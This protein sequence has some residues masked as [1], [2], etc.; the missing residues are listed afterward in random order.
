MNVH[1]KRIG[2]NSTARNHDS[3]IEI[4]VRAHQVRSQSLAT[5]RHLKVVDRAFL[6]HVGETAATTM[7][8]HNFPDDDSILQKLRTVKVKLSLRF[9]LR[10]DLEVGLDGQTVAYTRRWVSNLDLQVLS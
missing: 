1:P 3:K 9:T 10:I 6:S 4:L 8:Q 5:G 7:A 2:Q